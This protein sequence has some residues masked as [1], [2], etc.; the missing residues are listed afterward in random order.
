[1]SGPGLKEGVLKKNINY[2]PGLTLHYDQNI[3]SIDYAILDHRAGN[4][5]SFAYRL[6]GFDTIWRNDRKLRR[7]TYTNLPPGDYL[8]EVKSLS[9]DLYTSHAVQKADHYNSATAVENLVGLPVVHHIYRH[10]LFL[11]P[12][13]CT[14]HDSPAKQNCCRNKNLPHS[15]SIFSPIYPTS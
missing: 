7:A 9:S 5:Q 1:M 8:F 3:I 6:V 14:C 15:N 13:V 2:V 11:Y 12:Q 4:T 10:H